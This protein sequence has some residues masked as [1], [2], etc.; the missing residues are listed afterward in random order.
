MEEELSIDAVKQRMQ[1]VQSGQQQSG[2]GAQQ[3]VAS[4]LSLGAKDAD[5]ISALFCPV[6]RVFT[7]KIGQR[8]LYPRTTSC[9]I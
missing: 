8:R 9:V 7:R 4:I 2:N 1:E 3:N 6:L 5:S